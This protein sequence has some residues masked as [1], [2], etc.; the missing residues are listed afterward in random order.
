MEWNGRGSAANHP[1]VENF[2]RQVS[3]QARERGLLPQNPPE[4]CRVDLLVK[5]GKIVEMKQTKVGRLPLEANPNCI[6]VALPTPGEAGRKP[7]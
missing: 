6:N 5:L 1:A 2:H 3:L 7:K 4:R